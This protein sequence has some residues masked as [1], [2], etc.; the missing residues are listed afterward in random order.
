MF[1]GRKKPLN[2]FYSVFDR[3]VNFSPS[4]HISH[5]TGREWLE[6]LLSCRSG[7]CQMACMIGSRL[8]GLTVR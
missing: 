1:T 5:V 8:C 7:A 4:P 2:I 3:S 6:Q